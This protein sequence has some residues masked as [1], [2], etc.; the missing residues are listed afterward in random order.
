MKRIT[1]EEFQARAD[2][3]REIAQVETLIVTDGDGAPLFV[4]MPHPVYRQ[5]R[6]GNR[7]ALEASGLDPDELRDV[8][9]PTVLDRYDWPDDDAPENKREK[10][11][12]PPGA[13]RPARDAPA[14]LE[15]A[16]SGR[17]GRF[18]RTG[19][20]R[21]ALAALRALALL[22]VFIDGRDPEHGGERAQAPI[23]DPR[24]VEGGFE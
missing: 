18:A 15:G 19:V 11:G 13:R 21:L 6:K 10:G 5:L 3:F 8:A 20:Q 9:D 7:E 14:V 24:A 12:S 1:F 16:R 2:E 22:P 4:V 17:A 23:G